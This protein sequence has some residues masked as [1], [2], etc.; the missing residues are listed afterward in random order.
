MRKKI[1]SNLVLGFVFINFIFCPYISAQEIS[2]APSMAR[3]ASAFPSPQTSLQGI[4]QVQ[5]NQ[6]DQE[7]SLQDHQAVVLDSNSQENRFLKKGS[8]HWQILKKDQIIEAGDQIITGA[9]GFV[10]IRYDAMSKNIVKIDKKSKAE[11][12]SIEPTDLHLEDGS[13]FNILDGLGG[14]EY[15]ISTPT[16]V[17]AV[18]GTHLPVSY[19]ASTGAFYAAVLDENDSLL[20]KVEITDLDIEGTQ[21]TIVLDEGMQVETADSEQNILE[22]ESITPEKQMEFETEKSEVLDLLPVDEELITE[23]LAEDTSDGEESAAE[24][25]LAVEEFSAEEETPEG[26]TVEADQAMLSDSELEVLADQAIGTAGEEDLMNVFEDS[27]E[28]GAEFAGNGDANSTESGT[29][30]AG[31]ELMASELTEEGDSLAAEDAGEL[32]GTEEF[33]DSGAEME[34]PGFDEMPQEPGFSDDTLSF[35][36]TGS[37]FVSSDD[38]AQEVSEDQAAEETQNEAEAETEEPCT[39]EEC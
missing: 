13:L 29:A 14:V 10:V 22:P 2:S 3:A 7:K 33:S 16:A 25:E 18:R 31:S 28:I 32:G 9:N 11:F 5:V 6:A 8:D 38:V 23:S 1:L 12:R 21:K 15:Q 26:E 39:G 4:D 34:S 20:H 30:E 17:A 35:E 19:D 36:N 24:E 27:S 37:D